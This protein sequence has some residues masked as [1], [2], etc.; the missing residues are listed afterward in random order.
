MQGTA[1]RAAI[2]S[3]IILLLAG[4]AALTG[5]TGAARDSWRGATYDEV[6]SRWGTP[7]RTTTWF[8]GQA[9]HTWISET[10]ASRGRLYPSIGI[11]GSNDGIGIGTSVTVGP[12]SYER[13]RCE[14]TLVFSSGRVAEQHWTG[15]ADY[16]D[17]FRRK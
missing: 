8:D 16:C 2:V 5:A 10:T 12:G 9:T 6:V 7:A 14:R 15:S 4:C 11:F 1:V 13:V 3:F 17:E